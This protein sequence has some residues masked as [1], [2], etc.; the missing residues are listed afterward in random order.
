MAATLVLLSGGLDSATALAAATPDCAS[1]GALFICYGQAG[2]S[3][4]RRAAMAIANHY[5]VPLEILVMTGRRF[6]E[7]EI[8]GRNAF[9]VH[10]SLLAAPPGP[11]T[12][13]IGVHEGTGY[14]DCSPE[15]VELMQRSL[16]FHTSG[17]VTLV[18]GIACCLVRRDQ[19]ST[20]IVS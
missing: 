19:T 14:V 9:L 7:G 16:A 15:F 4:E 20:V 17:E 2:E 6:D 12:I 8:R 13:I 3:E 5:S 1:L 18:K 11:T 10:S